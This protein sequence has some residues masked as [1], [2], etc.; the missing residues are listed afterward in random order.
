MDVLH[1]RMFQW[2]QG[3]CT[4]IASYMDCILLNRDKVIFNKEPEKCKTV[5]IHTRLQ[6]QLI[7]KFINSVLP[8]LGDG[9]VLVIGGEDWTFPRSVDRRFSST[10]GIVV[11][12]L[13]NL[14]TN[15]KVKK[16]F[17]EN[18]DMSLP[19]AVPLPLGVNPIEK[20]LKLDDYL[21]FAN[22]SESKPLKFTNFNRLRGGKGQWAERGL[23]AE[24]SQGPWHRCFAGN[25]MIPSKEKDRYFT[26]MGKYSFTVCAHG[27]GVDP[28]PK[29]WDAL[30][31]G[32]IPIIKRNSPVTDIYEDMPVVIVDDWEHDTVTP[33]KL[34]QWHSMF[35]GVHTD[36]DKRVA[37]VERLTMDYWVNLIRET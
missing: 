24:L 31:L 18:L 34:Q 1:L 20:V 30:L 8:I 15:P 13:K 3:I 37:L 28:C 25:T 17:I 10:P 9:L 33:D 22:L 21:K 7:L 36:P 6:Y 32:V 14:C 5:F 2:R 12:Q 29:T 19:N 4:G 23:V 16:L 11:D 35:M 27:G 26:E